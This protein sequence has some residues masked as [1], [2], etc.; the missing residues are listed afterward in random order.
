[1]PFRGEA[2][3][4]ARAMG[5]TLVVLPEMAIPGAA[6]RDILFDPSF[7]EAVTAATLDLAVRAGDGPPVVF[8]TLLA[9]STLLGRDTR[10][11]QWP[12]TLCRLLLYRPSWSVACWAYSAPFCRR[13]SG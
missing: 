13:C 8:G 1:M 7:A 2:I 4:A 6:P 5:A 3:E 10:R 11:L 12:V 9:G